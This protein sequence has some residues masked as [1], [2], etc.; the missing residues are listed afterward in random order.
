MHFPRAM[1]PSATP[2][3]SPSASPKNNLPQLDWIPFGSSRRPGSPF[4]NP[5]LSLSLLS[6]ASCLYTFYLYAVQRK[7]WLRRHPNRVFVFRAK[8]EL[9]LAVFVIL[10]CSLEPDALWRGCPDCPVHPLS[11][12]HYGE[13][14]ATP[15]HAAAVLA[16]LGQYCLLGSELWFLVIVHDLASSVDNPFSSY[17]LR[18]TQYARAVH[19]VAF[20]VATLLVTLGGGARGGSLASTSAA[21]YGGTVSG[22]VW[23]QY[24]NDLFQPATWLCFYCWLAAIYV[25]GVRTIYRA[26]M[27]FRHGLPVSL[28]MRRK[29]LTRTRLVVIGC[30]RRARPYRRRAPRA[31]LRRAGL[32]RRVF[33]RGTR[34]GT[35]SSGRHA[36]S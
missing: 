23:I 5:L 9:A 35:P 6:I 14:D 31:A 11:R 21:Q 36:S 33:T 13:C 16:W 15:S 30:E 4:L 18:A 7:P 2:T 20:V 1:T 28:E 34:V 29:V 22:F 10:A 19:G 26:T 3:M 32:P 27:R 12:A 25:F 24:S 8:M 17:K